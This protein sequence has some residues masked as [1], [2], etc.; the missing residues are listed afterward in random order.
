MMSQ[1]LDQGCLQVYTGAG[2]GKTTAA[3]GQAW[4]ALGAGLRVCFLQFLKGGIKSSELKLAPQFG[5]QLTFT[6]FDHPLS[7]LIFGG[8]PTAEDHHKVQQAWQVAQAALS[9]PDYDLVVLDEINNAIHHG[10]VG[11][12][13]V[14]TALANRPSHQEVIC[15]GR[16]A[17][18]QLIEAADL[19]TE[20][21]AIK[22]SYDEGLQ[23]RRGIEM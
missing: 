22:H 4:R 18:A 6:H 1:H 23:A 20:M 3:L 13:E 21:R 19:V 5:P 17:P 16:D 14:L 2:K 10:L 7:S 8:S 11:I 9:N 15:T 12:S